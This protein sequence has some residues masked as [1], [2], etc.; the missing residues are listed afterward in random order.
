MNILFAPWRQEHVSTNPKTKDENTSQ[1]NCVFCSELAENNDEKN[2]ILKRYQHT[3][4]IF[5]RYPYNAGHLLI[6]PK[7][8][9]DTLCD[10]TVDESNELMETIKNANKILTNVLKPQGMNIG[11]N[12]GATAGASIPSH[13][14]MHILPRWQR[15]TSFLPLISGTKVCSFDLEE[16]FKKLVQHF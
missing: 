5:N 12:I 11:M 2:F 4:V 7:K 3:F 15:D 10:L 8:H 14:H 1:D 9:I 6:L 13:I 16:L